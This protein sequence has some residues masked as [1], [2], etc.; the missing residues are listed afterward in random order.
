MKPDPLFARWRSEKT[1]AYLC[2]AVAAAERSLAGKKLF[3]DMAGAAEEQA[4]IIAEEMQAK[5]VFR[6]SLRSRL[7]KKMIKTFGPR[8]M[9][10]IL[11]ATKVRGVSFYSGP[12]LRPGHPMPTD[13]E[14]IGERHRGGGGS[15]RAAVFGVNDG[16]ISNTSLVMGVSGAALAPDAIVLTGVAGL[17]AGAFS[18]AAGEYV[19]VRSQREMYEYQISQERE[20]L[21]L[22]PEEEAEE[23]ALIYHARGMPLED[24]RSIANDLIADPE[25]AL[26]ALTREELG[27]DP[28][29]LGS[30]FGAAMSSFLAF[31]GGAVIPLLPFLLG[32]K[33]AAIPVAAG[34]A[35]ASLFVIGAA[36]SLFSGKGALAGGARMLLIGA[37]AG[38]ATYFIGS[39]FGVAAA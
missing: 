9:R 6:P 36:L 16:L 39:L 32:A 22:Y 11:A 34:L 15:L 2:A 5:P 37:L 1:A 14:K 26:D 21:E 20:E 8:R 17:L 18:M 7:I 13:V 10:A 27:L 30:P 4:G 33:A 31:T 28:D 29:N 23:L 24:A 12:V 19:S 38:G 3:N 35:G 25:A